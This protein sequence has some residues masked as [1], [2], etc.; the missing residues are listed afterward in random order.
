MLGITDANISLARAGAVAQYVSGVVLFC[1]G[2][3]LANPVHRDCLMYNPHQDSW[4]N[5]TS[6][7]KGRDEAAITALK[8]IIYVIGGIGERT[9]EFIDMTKLQVN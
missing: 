5:F 8:N 9:V 3:S 2:Q 4:T 1:G 7:K 6:L